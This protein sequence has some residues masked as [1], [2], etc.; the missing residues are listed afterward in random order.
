MII[1]EIIGVCVVLLTLYFGIQ[2][3]RKNITIKKD[4]DNG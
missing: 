3:A 2:W 1:Y 4:D